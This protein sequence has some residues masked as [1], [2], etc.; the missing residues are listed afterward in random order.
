MSK[1]KNVERTGVDLN[2]RSSNGKILERPHTTGFLILE[3]K[4]P[5]AKQEEK[6]K[7][8]KVRKAKKTAINVLSTDPSPD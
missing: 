2:V 8:G 5:S 1:A 6:S 3:Q 7:G 4:P